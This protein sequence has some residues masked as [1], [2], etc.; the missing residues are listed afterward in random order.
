MND[1]EFFWLHI[2]KAGGQSIRRLMKPHYSNT[3]RSKRP[4]SFLQAPHKEHNDILNNYRTNLGEYQFRRTL[5]ARDYLYPE[6]WDQLYS[7]AF[8]R[9]P[10]DRCISM[11]HYLFWNHNSLFQRLLQTFKMLKHKKR[12]VLNKKYAFDVFLDLVT[13]TRESNSNYGPLGNHFS[14]HTASVSGDICDFDGDILLTKIYRLE[15]MIDGINEVFLVCGIEKRLSESEVVFRNKT[16]TRK[17]FSPSQSQLH[18][19]R[20]LYQQD[21]QIYEDAK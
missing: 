11:F 9:E 1:K 18:K 4:K 19:I 3:D 13:I 16:V 21:F 2:K 12:I 5:F 7:F 17:V 14:T 15:H 6:S 10:V 8:S 20:N